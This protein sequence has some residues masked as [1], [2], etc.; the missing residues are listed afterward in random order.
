MTALTDAATTAGGITELVRLISESHDPGT[1]SEITEYV[2]A[3]GDI[4][5][6]AS[7]VLDAASH[8]IS[9][10]VNAVPIHRD[11]ETGFLVNQFKMNG[12]PFP[13]AAYL[14]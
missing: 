1:S 4:A 13:S 5:A 2:K 12:R 7:T 11:P 3:A 6:S 8:V 9:A 14:C 10:Y